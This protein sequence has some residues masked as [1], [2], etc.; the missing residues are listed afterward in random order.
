MRGKP[1]NILPLW[2]YWRYLKFLKFLNPWLKIA[3]ER[4]SSPL[5]QIMEVNTLK[6]IIRIFVNQRVFEWNT[7]FHTHHNRMMWLR[8]KID[9]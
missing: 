7:K 3:S 2:S 1:S 6:E 8:G 9:H 4:G 5:D